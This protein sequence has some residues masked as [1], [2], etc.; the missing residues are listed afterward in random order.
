MPD[1]LLVAHA[2]TNLANPLILA[3]VGGLIGAAI[4]GIAHANRQLDGHSPDAARP[5]GPPSS[6]GRQRIWGSP[7]LGLGIALVSIG[8]I[9]GYAAALLLDNATGVRSPEQLVNE[10]CAAARAPDPGPAVV[11]LHDDLQHNLGDLEPDRRER[12]GR[13][14]AIVRSAANRPD[15][16]DPELVHLLAT[17]LANAAGLGGTPCE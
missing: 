15:P 3:A 17:E 7:T 10:L 14:A 12:A 13:A 11:S 6:A 16:L 2:S 9:A 8:L 5:T 1:G 4:T